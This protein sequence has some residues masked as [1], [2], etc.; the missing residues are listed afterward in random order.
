MDTLELTILF[1]T[2][3]GN[4]EDLAKKV[5]KKAE[6]NQVATKIVNLA[7]YSIEDLAGETAPV[8][9]IVST[10]G[11]GAPPPKCEAFFNALHAYGDPL[12]GKKFGV[13]ALGDSEY[14]LFCECGK[15]LDSKLE[16]LGAERMVERADMDAD[17]MVSYIGW[18]KRFWKTMAGVYGIKK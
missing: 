7:N 15:Q 17:F 4:C 1:G 11:D 16:A 13:L 6:K 10:W 8:L 9:F 14:P 3:T 5:A 12:E 18:S 2:E